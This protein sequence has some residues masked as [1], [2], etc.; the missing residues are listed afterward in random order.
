MNILPVIVRELRAG[1]RQP[2]NYWLRMLGAAFVVL[3]GEG[4][5]EGCHET[6][7]VGAGSTGI[8]PAGLPDHGVLKQVGEKPLIVLLVDLAPPAERVLA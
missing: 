5:F 8:I 1:A 7:R 2:A 6:V 4:V 3:G